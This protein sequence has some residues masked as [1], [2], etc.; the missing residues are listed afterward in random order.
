M[1]GL[2]AEWRPERPEV[3]SAFKS[4]VQNYFIE[5]NLSDILRAQHCEE[6]SKIIFSFTQK[7]YNECTGL[8]IFAHLCPVAAS[9]AARHRSP[10]V[11]RACRSGCSSW[12][13]TH[14]CR[15]TSELASIG[16][17]EVKSALSLKNKNTD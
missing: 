8:L 16:F 14:N 1:Q 13:P 9:C 12:D 10:R 5:A 4:T 15:E 2:L 3:I 11:N 17:L 7:V 6:V